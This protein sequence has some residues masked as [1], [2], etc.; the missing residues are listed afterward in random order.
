MASL[1][2]GAVTAVTQSQTEVPSVY[3]ILVPMSA[4]NIKLDPGDSSYVV[5]NPLAQ[6]A[7]YF[8]IG[9]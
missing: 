9:V 2:R 4:L 3:N 8:C 6:T 7:L 5:E 1:E